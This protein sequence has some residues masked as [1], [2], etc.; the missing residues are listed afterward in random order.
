M[1]AELIAEEMASAV[2]LLGGDGPAKAQNHRAARET[3]LSVTLIERVRW[4][5][6][7]RVPADIADVV[8]EAV[9][10]HQH[11]SLTRAKHELHLAQIEAESLKRRL[12]QFDPDYGRSFPLVDRRES[13]GDRRNPDFQG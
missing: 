8:R 13:S 12:Q 2:R 7:K 9:A 10:H 5:K 4:K 1:R 11:E 6:I 3:K